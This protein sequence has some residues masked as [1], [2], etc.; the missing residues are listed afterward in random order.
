MNPPWGRPK[1]RY[2]PSVRL[3]SSFG[4]K[5]PPQPPKGPSGVSSPEERLVIYN[6]YGDVI[7]DISEEEARGTVYTP[8]PPERTTTMIAIRFAENTALV[9]PFED[10]DEADAYVAR[11]RDYVGNAA[12]EDWSEERF[13]MHSPILSLLPLPDA[14]FRGRMKDE[15]EVTIELPKDH[16][17]EA[18]AR[19]VARLL[20][21]DVGGEKI[22]GR[23][24]EDRCQFVDHLESLI[25]ALPLR[26][27]CEKIAELKVE[28]ALTGHHMACHD[29]IGYFITR[30]GIHEP[31]VTQV[32][33][34]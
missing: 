25:T 3:G 5:P 28:G 19:E 24:V 29:H 34:F 18:I 26:V 7:L 4:L 8:T 30:S 14:G 13:V 20:Q 15:P 12:T 9:G 27:Q 31:T 22:D 23:R 17:P 33:P 16:D 32:H 1:R 21:Q 10:N 11:Y 6:H 2:E